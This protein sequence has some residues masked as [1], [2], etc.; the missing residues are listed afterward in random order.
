[1][2]ISYGG[3]FYAFLSAEAARLDVKKSGIRELVDLAASV[4]GRPFF[5]SGF[6]FFFFFPP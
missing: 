6:L 2:D 1:M 3:A 5:K 4:T